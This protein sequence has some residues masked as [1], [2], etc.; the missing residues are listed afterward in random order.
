M[1][2]NRRLMDYMDVYCPAGIGH[3]T[4]ETER[5]KREGVYWKTKS[6]NFRLSS[7]L[8]SEGIVLLNRNC[9]MHTTAATIFK[10]CAEECDNIFD[11]DC[12]VSLFSSILR[13]FNR[14]ISGGKSFQRIARAKAERL[15]QT[16]RITR[17]TV[18]I[19]RRY[20]L[21]RLCYYLSNVTTHCTTVGWVLI[22]Y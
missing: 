8:E 18:C 19:A 14:F 22:E 12:I 5:N 4:A 3:Y 15:D 2:V 1:A 20:A 10:D 6:D 11:I 17:F 7:G 16:N 13:F 9:T 21:Q